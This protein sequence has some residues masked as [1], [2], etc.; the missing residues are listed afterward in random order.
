MPVKSLASAP[1]GRYGGS[2]LENSRH[3]ARFWYRRYIKA[4]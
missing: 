4:A 3:L 1:R 2:M